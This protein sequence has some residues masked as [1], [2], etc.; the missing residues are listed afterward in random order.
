MVLQR[1]RPEL[2][3][4]KFEKCCIS[5]RIYGRMGEGKDGNSWQ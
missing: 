2:R 1:I 3:V 4:K 5:N